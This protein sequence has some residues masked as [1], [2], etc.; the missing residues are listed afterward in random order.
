MKLRIQSNLLVRVI[1][2]GIILTFA[3]TLNGHSDTTGIVK[4]RRA[5]MKNMG[6]A[7]KVIGDMFKRKRSFH[8]AEIR[9]LAARIQQ[10]AANIPEFFPDTKDSREG[11]ATEAKPII[12]EQWEKFEL[13]SKDLER[14][15]EKLSEIAAN[16][17]EATIRK[18]YVALAKTCLGC[19]KTYRRPKDH[20]D[21]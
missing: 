20:S 8:A 16:G 13:L 2:F 3:A 19:H 4:E 15:S 6:D 1:S 7:N 9:S 12:W 18:Q 11:H 14:E 17:G 10:H 5:E 21:H